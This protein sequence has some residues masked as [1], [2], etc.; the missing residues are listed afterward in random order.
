[1]STSPTTP[2]FRAEHIGSLLR[3][4]ELLAMRQQFANG[5]ANADE[6]RTAED[7]AV[8]SAIAM[9]D[10]VGLKVVTDGEYRRAAYHDFF[11]EHLG[12]VTIGW[13]PVDAADARDGAKRAAQPIAIVKSALRWTAPIH[14]GEV[15]FLK[16]HSA[17][18]PKVTLPG[19]C[20]LH[21]RGGA[22]EILRHGAYTDIDAFWSDIVESYARELAS[23]AAAGCS[24]VQIDE[25][26]FAK[27]ADQ[28]VRDALAARGED[29]QDMIDLYIDVTNRV[30]ARAPD[31]M[32]IG[33]HLCRGNRGGHF[34]AEG[35]Y[36]VVAEKLF[37]ALDIPFY[38]LEYDSPRAGDFSP[39]RH[40]PAT[41]SVVLGLVSTKSED[42][43]TRDDLKRRID[44]AAVYVDPDRLAIS[45]Q[46]GFASVST[47]N[48]ITPEIQEA[49]LRL[50]VEVADEVWAD[51]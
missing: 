35:G 51:A 4:P 49:K 31:T 10:R 40:L 27:F 43:E 11:F 37:N 41:K 2:P 42:F 18:M 24:Y 1:M 6:Q 44:A 9:Q 30:L 15:A 50:V 21:F 36:D 5:Q 34:H 13:P 32:R 8:V 29:W 17:A 28:D 33:M 22:P 20:A 26:A 19:P 12:D 25:T 47:G 46:C 48:P 39:L 16:Q 23:L 14:D 38:F 3:P 7:A 45:P